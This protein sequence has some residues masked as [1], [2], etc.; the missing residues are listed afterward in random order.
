MDKSE[1]QKHP[2]FDSRV[3]VSATA[4]DRYFCTFPVELFQCPS[5]G[6]EAEANTNGGITTA[7]ASPVTNNTENWFPQGT[8]Y[9]AIPGTHLKTQT[10]LEENGILVSME[11][12]RGGMRQGAIKDGISKTILV[13]ESKEDDWSCWYDGQVTWV[14]GMA[15]TSSTGTQL[16]EDLNSSQD[17]DADGVADILT[18]G[19][20]WRTG[21][22]VG[23]VRHSDTDD[24]YWKS[25]APYTE[26]NGRAWGPSS[27]HSGGVVMHVFADDHIDAISENIENR[28]YYA[29]VTANGRENVTKD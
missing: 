17:N 26:D 21:L 18:D 14:T 11:K 3:V 1:K 24:Y 28:V 4:G 13:C 6:G 25:A 10:E 23:P 7:W 12:R 15:T 27:D 22:N 29:M 8:N 16:A 19:T 5:F 9:V 20:T 2:A